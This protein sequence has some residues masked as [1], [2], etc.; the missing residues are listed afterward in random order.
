MHTWGKYNFL[1]VQ[2]KN[3]IKELNDRNY[4]K[5]FNCKTQGYFFSQNLNMK[6]RK[7]PIF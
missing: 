3:I 2:Y 6:L 1:E 4:L 5:N 7:V